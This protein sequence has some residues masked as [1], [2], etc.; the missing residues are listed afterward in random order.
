M[1]T[2]SKSQDLLCFSHLRWNF[3]FQRPQHLM[4]RFAKTRRV[5]FIEEPLFEPD[6]PDYL[7]HTVC[8]RT[9]VHVLTPVLA[10]EQDASSD[11][12]K[13]LVQSYLK[14][15]KVSEPIVWFYSPMCLD[16][17]PAD[18]PA[19]AVVYDCMDELSL[20][21]GAPPRL[22]VNEAELMKMADLVF[23]GGV[24]LFE[25]KRSRH[26]RVY[27]FPSGVDI[28]H[29][30]QARASCGE[31]EEQAGIPHPRLGYAG[32]IDERMDLQLI[33]EA[34][35]R[36][37]DWHFI[38]IGPVVKID[39]GSL[40]RAHNL[41]WLGMQDYHNLPEF[42]A[43]WDLAIMPFAINDATRF[44]SPTKTPEFLAAGLPVVSTPVRD[45]VRPYG[46]L[47]LARIA[48]N[49]KEFVDAAEQAMA[50]TM[51]MKW[52]ERADAF[53]E[54]MSWD[55]VWSSMNALV[56]ELLSSRQARVDAG[57]TSIEGEEARV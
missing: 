35:Q 24:S 55:S 42:F 45:V 39:T 36:R 18:T 28:A 51:G 21:K 27:P 54:T 57:V 10:H 34:A 5:F 52:R 19:S 50:F 29:F 6:S 20:F 48:T 32:V 43:G 44:I 37:P 14:S 9:G 26:P 49:A 12:I 47:G 16:S 46:E 22:H 38:M 41:H 3:V 31:R 13:Q 40:P 33:A 30:A 15:E 53:L 56:E 8:S 1:T 4:S 17:F 23:T 2:P 7:R 25:F 11:R